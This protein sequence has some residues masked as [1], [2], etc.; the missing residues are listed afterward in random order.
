MRVDIAKKVIKKVKKLPLKA[1]NEISKVLYEIEGFENASRI[2]HDGKLKGYSDIYKIRVGDYR[3]IYK[4]VTATHIQITSVG[5]RKY[6]YKNL[7][8]IVFS[9]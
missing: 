4:K 7:L 6:I 2:D 1:A 8:E 5:D 3:I 9:L